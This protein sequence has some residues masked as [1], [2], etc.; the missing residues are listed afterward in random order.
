MSKYNTPLWTALITPFLD[1]GRIDFEA[2]NKLVRK[3]EESKNGIL[4]LGST[5]EALNLTH[6]EKVSILDYIL[7]LNPTIPVMVGVGGFDL[8]N[9]KHWIEALN[10]REGIHS[11]LMVTPLYAKPGAHGQ[12]LWF[13]ALLESSTRPCML[14]N[15]PGRTGCLLNLDALIKLQTHPN[16]WGVKDAGGDPKESLRYKES[17]PGIEFFCGDDGLFQSFFFAGNVGLI[18]VAANVW[19]AET[20]LYVRKVLDNKFEDAKLWEEASDTLFLASN[21]IPVKSLMAQKKMISTPLMKAPLS[22]QDLE[23]IEPLLRADREIQNWYNKN[24]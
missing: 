6:E 17:L 18:S 20:A 13:S 7:S 12:Y 11:Y 2:L 5:A 15:V 10:R 23:N 22:H 4:V 16:F 9:T 24:K 3:Q 8:A 21:P 14:Y 1:D 19:P